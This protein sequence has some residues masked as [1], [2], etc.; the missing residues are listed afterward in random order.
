[1]GYCQ[2]ATF[3]HIGNSRFSQEDNFLVGDKTFLTEKRRNEVSISRQLYDELVALS[4]V[5]FCSF[6][7]DGMGRHAH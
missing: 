4:S 1:M 6:V 2:I 7:C 5:D 3:S